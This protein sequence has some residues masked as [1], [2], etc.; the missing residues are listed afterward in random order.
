MVPGVCICVC[1]CVW[2]CVCMCVYVRL[3]PPFSQ[4]L[5]GV[6]RGAGQVYGC[7]GL[8]SSGLIFAATLIF[9]PV[10][11]SQAVIGT[12]TGAFCGKLHP[13]HPLHTP[14]TLKTPFVHPEYILKSLGIYLTLNLCI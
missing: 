13:Y 10:V 2:V 6:V 5:Q 4:V 8:V 11:F 12:L 9:S 3:T 7:E 14:C 1:M